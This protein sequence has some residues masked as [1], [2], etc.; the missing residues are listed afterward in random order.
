MTKE[1]KRALF[2]NHLTV[3]SADVDGSDCYQRERT[4]NIS[5]AI[6]YKYIETNSDGE[7]K[8]PNNFRMVM[9]IHRLTNSHQMQVQF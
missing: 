1:E 8:R 4:K 3:R 5:V 7:K 2:Q 9:Y 6:N